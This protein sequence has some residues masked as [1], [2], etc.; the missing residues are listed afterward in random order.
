MSEDRPAREPLFELSTGRIEA[1]GDGVFA[2]AMTLLVLEIR[3][4]S[5]PAGATNGDLWDGLARMWPKLI[6]YA[7]S[8]ITLGVYWVAHHLHFVT[9]RRADRMLLWIN[10]LFLLCIGFAPFSTALIGEHFRLP[11]AVIVYGANLAVI[12]LTL[13]LHWWYATAH[14]RLV[15]PELD[16]QFVRSVQQVIMVGPVVYL[17]GI[18][19]S[20]FSTTVSVV[21]YVLVTVLYILPGGFH[22][23]LKSA[24]I[25][26]EDH[27]T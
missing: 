3:V 23:H 12:G 24:K 5:L 7:F 13:A 27:R 15:S 21:L 11:A 14:H 26:R 22:L 1:L 18:A 16:P 20:S 10:L 19:C 4:P 2:I 9:I 25:A 6:C 8:F 17:I